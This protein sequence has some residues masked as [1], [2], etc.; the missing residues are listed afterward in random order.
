MNGRDG[1]AAQTNLAAVPTISAV[2]R[3]DP[4]S[5]LL[6]ASTSRSSCLHKFLLLLITDT[7]SFQAWRCPCRR[8]LATGRRVGSSPR[9]PA[10]RERGRQRQQQQQLNSSMFITALNDAFLFAFAYMV[11]CCPS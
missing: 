1:W 7:T 8:L 2:H 4:R 3:I 6:L 11:S 9:R 5:A 10:A